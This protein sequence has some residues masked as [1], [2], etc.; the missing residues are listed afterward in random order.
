MKALDWP[1]ATNSWTLKKN[2]ET[3]LEAYEMKGL[4]KILR[5]SWTEMSGIPTKLE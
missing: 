4:K 2:E 1:A 3:C 5:V